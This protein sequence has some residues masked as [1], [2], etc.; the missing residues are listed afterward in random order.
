MLFASLDM[1]IFYSTKLALQHS[2]FKFGQVGRPCKALYDYCDT[3]APNPPVYYNS[4]TPEHNNNP[5]KF[6]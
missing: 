3:I 5:L 6:Q 4:K 2:I 1:L